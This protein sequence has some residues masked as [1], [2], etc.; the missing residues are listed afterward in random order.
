MFPLLLTE[1][2]HLVTGLLQRLNN[3]LIGFFLVHLL[4]LFAG[5]FFL[6][7]SKFIFQLLNDIQVCVGDLLVIVLDIVVFLGMLLCQLFYGLIL[8]VFNLLDH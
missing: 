1:L 5:V 6:G 3:L 7:I 2:L 4:L 8:L